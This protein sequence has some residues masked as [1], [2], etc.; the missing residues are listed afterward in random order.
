MSG[1]DSV[2]RCHLGRRLTYANVAIEQGQSE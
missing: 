2:W 1:T